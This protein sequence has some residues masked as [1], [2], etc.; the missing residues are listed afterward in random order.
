MEKS[1]ITILIGLAITFIT[2]LSYTVST[3]KTSVVLLESKFS[4]VDENT[5]ELKSRAI[6]LNQNDLINQNHEL[7]IE[8]LEKYH[9]NE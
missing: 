3:T 8:L 9:R 4:K 5:L 1:T 6:L 2:W 7:R